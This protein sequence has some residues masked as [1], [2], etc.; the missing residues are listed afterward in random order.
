MLRSS[1]KPSASTTSTTSNGVSLNYDVPSSSSSS[2]SSS[3][4]K[5]L[6]CH[7]LRKHRPAS[8]SVSAS[9]SP[10]HTRA[11]GLSPTTM[12]EVVIDPSSSFE[13]SS[14]VASS[15]TGSFSRS[16]SAAAAATH[17]TTLSTSLLDT[18]LNEEYEPIGRLLGSSYGGGGGSYCS[19]THDYDHNNSNDHNSN[20]RDDNCINNNNDN[21]VVDTEWTLLIDQKIALRMNC[22]Y[23]EE[24]AS[25]RMELQDLQQEYDLRRNEMMNEMA[26]LKATREKLVVKGQMQV[27]PKTN[28]N[29][30][31]GYNNNTNN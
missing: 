19:Y 18:T 7:V 20:H 27:Q 1:S 9:A 3:P 17:D 31:T 15:R 30:G 8:A 12:T 22:G 13:E 29:L 4:P 24:I 11:K 21:K 5:Q 26:R 16:G 14:T 2:S 6:D 28:T 10:R 23:A 25:K